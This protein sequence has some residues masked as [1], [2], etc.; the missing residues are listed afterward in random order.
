MPDG[1]YLLGGGNGSVGLLM[2]NSDGSVDLSF[3]NNGR[4]YHSVAAIGRQYSGIQKLH[5]LPDGR[6]Q[7]LLTTKDDAGYYYHAPSFTYGYHF[8]Y[9]TAAQFL[10]DGSLDPTFGVGGLR[11][12]NSGGSNAEYGFLHGSEWLADGRVLLS[13]ILWE[14]GGI[15]RFTTAFDLD[16]TFAVDGD[17]LIHTRTIPSSDEA[18][19]VTRWPDSGDGT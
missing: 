12:I 18:H 3:G 11:R 14:H 19:G 15:S 2:M 9:R 5:V 13:N 6:V 17:T 1:R 7:S 10:P 4:V 8:T 16:T